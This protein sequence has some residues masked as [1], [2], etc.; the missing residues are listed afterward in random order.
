[1]SLVKEPLRMLT[2][3]ELDAL[4]AQGCEEC[5][6]GADHVHGPNYLHVPHACGKLHPWHV[7]YQDHTLVLECAVCHVAIL[8]TALPAT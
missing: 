1:M 4:S 5:G 2:L 3:Q 8:G 7:F 6:K